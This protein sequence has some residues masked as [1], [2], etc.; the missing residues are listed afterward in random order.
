MLGLAVDGGALQ[1]HHRPLKRER[2]RLHHAAF[3]IDHSALTRSRTRSRSVSKA[4]PVSATVGKRDSRQRRA[5]VGMLR[6][7]V[8]KDAPPDS[9]DVVGAFADRFDDRSRWRS[10]TSTS[11]STVRA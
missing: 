2:E 11:A 8:G 3:A 10:V 7:T 6:G 9:S 1:R 4:A 5:V